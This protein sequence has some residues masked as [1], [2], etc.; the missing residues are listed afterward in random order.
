MAVVTTPCPDRFHTPAPPFPDRL[1]LDGPV[2]PACLGPRVGQSEKVEATLPPSRW[3]STWRPLARTHRRLFGMHGQAEARTPLRQDLHHPAGVGFQR[4]ADDAIIGKTRQKAPALP[5]GLPVFDTPCIQDAMQAYHS[6]LW[7]R[8]LRL[9]V[10]LCPGRSMR[11]TPGHPPGAT[12]RV[13][14]LFPHR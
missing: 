2:S 11:P 7:A 8:A 1:A 4:A 3:L 12:C 6:T 14:S 5:P 13:V 9:A 10:S